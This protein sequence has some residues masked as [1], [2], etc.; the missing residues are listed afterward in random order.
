VGLDGSE[1]EPRYLADKFVDIRID[2]TGQGTAK[3]ELGQTTEKRRILRF[4]PARFGPT[5]VCS[6]F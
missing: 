4:F 5:V 3:D 1:P 2:R 6:D